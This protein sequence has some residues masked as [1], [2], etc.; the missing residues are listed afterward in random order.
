MELRT[1]EGYVCVAVKEAVVGRED[2]L[3]DRQ[4]FFGPPTDKAMTIYGYESMASNHFTPFATLEDAKS[5]QAKLKGRRDFKRVWIGYFEMTMAESDEENRDPLFGNSDSIVVVM[6]FEFDWQLVGKLTFDG[7]SL[8][9]RLGADLFNNGLVP[10][11]EFGMA[12]FV[13]N[14]SQRQAWTLARLATFSLERV[15]G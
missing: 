7:I 15:A 4:I 12:S 3:I 11:T 1:I 5:A 8:Y 10:F 13:Q 2:V 9:P 6:Q 14:D